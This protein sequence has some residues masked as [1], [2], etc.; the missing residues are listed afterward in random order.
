MKKEEG[1]EETKEQ[2][3]HS[4]DT[5]DRNALFALLFLTGSICNLPGKSSIQSKS[6]SLSSIPKSSAILSLDSCLKTK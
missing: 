2:R 4:Y 3:E 1:V 5:Y 6:S